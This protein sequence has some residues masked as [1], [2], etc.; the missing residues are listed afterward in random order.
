MD[1]LLFILIP[2]LVGGL[3][4]ALLIA[5]TRRGTAATFVP[6]RLEAP[7]PSLI[8]MANIRVEG[9]GGLGM[10][11]AVVIVA[12][13]DSRIGLATI[14]A[15]VLGGAL[16]LVLIT[17]RRQNGSLPS[18]GGGPEDR[19][20]LHLEGKDDAVRADARRPVSASPPLPYSAAP[21]RL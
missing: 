17:M 9:V 20:V 2:G 13:A 4:L 19:S 16:A 14:M 12:V 18:A 5:S 11:G 21:L 1:P 7:S 8:N 6:K 10:V 15:L 3:V